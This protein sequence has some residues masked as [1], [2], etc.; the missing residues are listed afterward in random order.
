MTVSGSTPLVD[1]QSART[2]VIDRELLDALPTP[3]N[4][5]RSALR[6]GPAE[7]SRMWAAQMEQVNMRVHGA[8]AVHT[9]MQVDGM[10]VN[11][12]WNDG[13]IQNYLNQAQF[14]ETSFTTSSQGAEVSAGGVRVNMIPKDGGN[15]F[16]GSLYLGVTEKPF[17]WEN[18]TPELKAQGVTLPTGVDHVRDINPSIGG[19]IVR[20]RLWFFISMRYTSVN[21]HA[22]NSYMPDGSVAI[23]D[24]YVTDP[25]A[26]LTAQLSPKNKF[27]VFLDRPFKFKGREFGQTVEPAYASTRRNWSRVQYHTGAA[28]FTSTVSSRILFET[29]YVDSV[30][31]TGSG[32]QPYL[33]SPPDPEGLMPAVLQLIPRPNVDPGSRSSDIPSSILSQVPANTVAASGLAGPKQIA[34]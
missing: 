17:Q 21:E 1:V 28:K 4:T 6:R 26:R 12:A 31:R 27:S 19:P 25:L 16:S 23:V 24:Q 29:G 32:Y 30:L 11:T 9:T 18:L 15:I 14:G 5:H 8:S 3:R 20:D 7:Q 34:T 13:I 10:L 2:I 33:V 22:V